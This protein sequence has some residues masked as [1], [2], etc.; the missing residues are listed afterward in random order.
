MKNILFTLT[1]LISFNP[2]AQNIEDLNSEIDIE[3]WLDKNSKDEI[4][5]IWVFSV[6]NSNTDEKEVYLKAAILRADEQSK[7][8]SFQSI[9]IECYNR[10]IENCE[11]QNLVIGDLLEEI[12]KQHDGLYEFQKNGKTVGWGTLKEGALSID[13]SG[14]LVSVE[15]AYHSRPTLDLGSPGSIKTSGG[16]IKFNRN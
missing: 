2:F 5:G 16:V 14:L 11:K 6:I 12:K 3:N 15:R 9:M 1:L 10:F 8:E 4:E 7:R 13:Y